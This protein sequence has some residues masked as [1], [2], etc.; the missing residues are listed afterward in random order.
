VANVHPVVTDRVLA[1]AKPIAATGPAPTRVLMADAHTTTPV[2]LLADVNPVA[3]TVPT[4][5]AGLVAIAEPVPGAV[6]A[7]GAKPSSGTNRNHPVVGGSPS[8]STNPA[9]G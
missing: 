2:A 1:D 3:G 4:V 6:R 8:A 9:T 5:R 7:S